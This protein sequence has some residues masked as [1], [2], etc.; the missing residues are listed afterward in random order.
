LVVGN[1]QAGKD[2]STKA[3]STRQGEARQTRHEFERL[4][5]FE[6]LDLSKE[7]AHAARRD[8]FLGIEDKP[9]QTRV[10]SQGDDARLVEA[11]LE[12]HQFLASH[13]E[14]FDPGSCLRWH[15]RWQGSVP[16]VLQHKA[17]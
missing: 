8:F 14:L 4:E 13:L 10:P 12:P 9:A 2:A 5:A 17:Q 6:V 7:Q 11:F 16:Q 1:V 15:V 3:A